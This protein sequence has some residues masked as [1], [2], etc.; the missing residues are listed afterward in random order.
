[1]IDICGLNA[2]EYMQAKSMATVEVTVITLAAS[3]GAEL[4][5]SAAARA[6]AGASEVNSLNPNE[7][8]F[9]QRSVSENVVKYT[10][11]MKSGNW[12]WSKSGPLKVMERDGQWVS[13]DNRRLMAAQNAGLDSVPVQVVKPYDL[14]PGKSIVWEKAFTDIRFNDPRNIKLGGPVPNSGLGVQPEIIYKKV[15]G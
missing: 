6:N 8:N 3:L 11:D 4:A 14:V 10:E 15:G 12:D 7:I 1:M 13:Y 2:E 9:S 5:N